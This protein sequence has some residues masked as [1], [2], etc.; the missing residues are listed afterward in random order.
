MDYTPCIKSGLFAK[1]YCV[2]ELCLLYSTKAC[3]ST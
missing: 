2:L 1:I 3:L